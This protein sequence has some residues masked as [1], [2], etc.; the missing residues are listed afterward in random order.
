M[1]LVVV[2]VE[3]RVISAVLC[4]I[5]EAIERILEIVREFS[6]Q[7]CAYTSSYTVNFAAAGT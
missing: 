1:E 5:L 7:I 2:F 4:E 6:G 3:N